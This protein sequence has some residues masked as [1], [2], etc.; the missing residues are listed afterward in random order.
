MGREMREKGHATACAAQSQRGV[1][2]GGGRGRGRVG[3]LVLQNI[4]RG[5]DA[6]GMPK[7]RSSLLQAMTHKG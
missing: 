4:E 3:A 1:A 6:L 5:S 2:K 7:G